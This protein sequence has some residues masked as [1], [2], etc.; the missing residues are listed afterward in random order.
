MR[1]QQIKIFCDFDGT[2]TTKDV[3]EHMFYQFGDSQKAIE[4]FQRWLRKEIDSAQEWTEL[5]ALVKNLTE[6]EFNEFLSTI[7]IRYGFEEFVKFCADN[8]IELTILSDG[9]DFYIKKI[10][11]INGFQELKFYSNSLIFTDNG[12]KVSFPYSDEECKACAN[13]KRNHI[14]ENSGDE[15]ITMYIGDGY[16]DTCPVQ[17]VDYIFAKETLLKFCEKERISYFPFKNFKDVIARISPLLEKSKIKKRH[18]AELKRKAVY[19]QG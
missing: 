6:N 2:I 13:C 7:E 19:A 12:P 1:E 5:L 14:I 9:M 4:I 3:G 8:E 11:E 10:F 16:S 15:D 17:Y 18:Q